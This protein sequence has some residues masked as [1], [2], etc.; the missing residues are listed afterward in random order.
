MFFSR[1]PRFAGE[2]VLLAAVLINLGATDACG[3]LGWFGPGK[4]RAG[5]L[6]ACVPVV[7]GC[8]LKEVVLLPCR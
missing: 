4:R 5:A 6:H 8:A 7:F 3:V 2:K 1:V